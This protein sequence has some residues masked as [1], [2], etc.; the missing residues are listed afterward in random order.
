MER[1]AREPADG[2][3]GAGLNAFRPQTA[4][5]SREGAFF[6]AMREAFL[7]MAAMAFRPRRC[8]A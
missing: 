7:S 5:A 8:D 4:E 6:K 3:D 2:A 1:A